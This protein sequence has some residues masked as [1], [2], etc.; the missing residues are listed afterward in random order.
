[1]YV[2]MVLFDPLQSVFPAYTQCSQDWSQIHAD[3]AKD[4]CM[5]YT[6]GTCAE[7]KATVF[8]SV[9][10]HYYSH[11]SVQHLCISVLA[12]ACH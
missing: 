8:V 11:A 10:V 4:E 3:Q 1:M 9:F 5:N 7:L 2:H 12:Y 6:E